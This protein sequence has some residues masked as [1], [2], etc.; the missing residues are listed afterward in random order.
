MRIRRRIHPETLAW[1]CLPEDTGNQT[2]RAVR[3]LLRG[4][5]RYLTGRTLRRNPRYTVPPQA[6]EALARRNYR[7]WDTL[8]VALDQAFGVAHRCPDPARLVK[9]IVLEWIKMG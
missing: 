6:V 5:Y 3:R 8:N 2:P 4:I 1:R 7:R 9:A